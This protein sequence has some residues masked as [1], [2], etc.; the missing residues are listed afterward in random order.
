MGVLATVPLIYFIVY[1]TYKL[2]TWTKTFHMCKKRTERPT[3]LQSQEPDRLL[4]PEEYETEE[5]KPHL[6]GDNCPQ[7]I[8]T[9][10][11]PPCGNSQQPNYW[12]M[13]STL[14]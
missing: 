1:V 13:Y 4:H 12:A 8:E 7:D 10:T 9:E 3:G 11:Y 14:A 5:H 2:L 6:V